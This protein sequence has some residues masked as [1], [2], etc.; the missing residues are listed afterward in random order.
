MFGA[1]EGQADEV[2]SAPEN[3]VAL[4]RRIRGTGSSRIIR[5]TMASSKRL[6]ETRRKA[7]NIRLIFNY[8]GHFHSTVA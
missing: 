5:D 1:E 7:S 4:L 2:W 6:T 8:Y 3:M